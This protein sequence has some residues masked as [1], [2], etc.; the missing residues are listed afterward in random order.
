MVVYEPYR[1]PGESASGSTEPCVCVLDGR[2]CPASCDACPPDCP[3]RL[4]TDPAPAERSPS[5]GS[6]DDSSWYASTRTSS[7]P[8][9]RSSGR[10]FTRSS[11]GSSGGSRRSSGGSASGTKGG[12]KK[13]GAGIGAAAT[14]AAGG[15]GA[16]QSGGDDPARDTPE[17][18]FPTYSN[19][20]SPYPGLTSVEESAPIES[21]RIE[22]DG[23]MVVVTGTWRWGGCPV[24]VEATEHARRVVTR[25]PLL[26]DDGDVLLDGTVEVPRVEAGTPGI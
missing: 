14:A 24:T 11:G 1:P 5:Y 4:A 23:R 9:R 15:F 18:G 21:F 20:A 10:S 25:G 6:S 12:G 26:R 19:H 8:R 3:E 17:P 22:Q 13:A 16:L 7:R 2:I